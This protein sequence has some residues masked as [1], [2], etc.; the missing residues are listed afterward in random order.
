MLVLERQAKSSPGYVAATERKSAIKRG[1]EAQRSCRPGGS[2]ERT[3]HLGSIR[4]QHQRLLNPHLQPINYFP[5][6][7]APF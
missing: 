5:C 1:R 6:G 2:E 3:Q 4:T 7:P